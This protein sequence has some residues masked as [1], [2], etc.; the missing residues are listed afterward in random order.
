MQGPI[1][2]SKLSKKLECVNPEM[3]ETLGFPFQKDRDR[4]NSSLSKKIAS[5]NFSSESVTMVTKYVSLT[6]LGASFLQ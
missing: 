5:G 2:E 3:R 1:S 6:W 4:V